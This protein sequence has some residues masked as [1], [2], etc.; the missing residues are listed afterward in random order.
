MSTITKLQ[1]SIESDNPTAEDIKEIIALLDAGEI[2]V[3]EKKD[4]Q[5]VVN[6]WVKTAVL[7]YFG[8]MQ[9]E[10]SSAGVLKFRD[11]IPLKEDISHARIVPGGNA[12]RY[13]SYVAEGVVM[14]PPSYVNIGAFVDEGTMIDSHVLVGSCAQIGKHVH[15]SAAVQIGGVLEPVQ[16]APVIIEDN[17]FIS[18]GSIIVEGVRVEEGAVIGAGV[19]LSASTKIIEVDPANNY[20]QVNEY[21]GVVPKNAIV[22]PGVRPKGETFGFQTPLLIGYRSESTDA[23]VS[24][25]EALRNF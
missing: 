15:L 20:E 2:R 24:L 7:K 6:E 1:Q 18:A 11:K 10:E 14:M 16:A 13:G 12:I 22:I 5:W 19:I 9:M 8:V 23:K 25:T 17:A 21:V 4:T 3:A